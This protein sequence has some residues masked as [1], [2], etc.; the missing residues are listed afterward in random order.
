MQSDTVDDEEDLEKEDD[1]EYLTCGL[2]S[3]GCSSLV[4]DDKGAEN[5]RRLWQ[6][7]AQKLK[8]PRCYNFVYQ[9][10]RP[11]LAAV[12]HTTDKTLQTVT[13]DRSSSDNSL[14]TP[15]HV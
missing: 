7:H 4:G 3:Q 8:Y 15:E 14:H 1:E 12:R 9:L 13:A 10:I 6:S 11:S 2:N 5:L